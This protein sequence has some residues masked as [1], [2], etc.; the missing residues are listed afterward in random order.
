MSGIKEPS[1]AVE[2]LKE[3]RRLYRNE[4][5]PTRRAIK[6]KIAALKKARDVFLAIQSNLPLRMDG[7]SEQTVED[8][9][10]AIHALTLLTSGRT[11]D[12][13]LD[14]AVNYL[15]RLYRAHTGTPHYLKVGE[16]VIKYF[17]D[18]LPSD[19]VK[20]TVNGNLGEWARKKATRYARHLEKLA[21]KGMSQ[22]THDQIGKSILL[23]SL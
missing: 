21:G 20:G 7:R 23:R 15:A 19:I 14:A 9:G 6:N 5:R 13:V 10:L 16:L 3:R 18:V 4:R 2:Y 17:S 12:T 1:W 8:L 11:I 22:E